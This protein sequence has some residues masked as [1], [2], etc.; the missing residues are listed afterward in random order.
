MSTPQ[1]HMEFAPYAEVTPGVEI[2]RFAQGSGTPSP[3]IAKSQHSEASR[4]QTPPTIIDSPNK[5]E[6]RSS[7]WVR[8]DLWANA[9]QGPTGEWDKD[10]IALNRMQESLKALDDEIRLLR[11][12]V[13]MW[14]R[15]RGDAWQQV[16]AMVRR[17]SNRE[18]PLPQSLMHIAS[19]EENRLREES[20]VRSGENPGAVPA[21]EVSPGVRATIV[22]EQATWLIALDG[23]LLGMV[24]SEL[25]GY[26]RGELARLRALRIDADDRGLPYPDIE[27]ELLTDELAGQAGERS[28]LV[29]SA[30]KLEH[31]WLV[32]CLHRVL[33]VNMRWMQAT[34]IDVR[35]EVAPRRGF[36]ELLAPYRKAD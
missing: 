6:A 28:L 14:R 7:S 3:H 19:D 31:Q 36:D 16:A 24:G 8:F 15:D 32:G 33:R 1:P 27:D 35:P 30:G 9:H 23:W 2:V 26:A 13:G 10:I 18:R 4:Y 25:E 12:L 21:T 34:K 29:R 22:R 20:E 11:L 17:I 5:Q